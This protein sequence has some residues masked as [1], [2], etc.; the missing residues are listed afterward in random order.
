[1]LT[2]AVC[3]ARVCAQAT[4]AKAHP[5]GHEED[6]NPRSHLMANSSSVVEHLRR[7]ASHPDSAGPL[8]RTGPSGSTSCLGAQHG[9]ENERWNLTVELEHGP[10]YL[11]FLFDPP[12][13]SIRG[14]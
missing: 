7:C 13:A 14:Q 5:Q 9:P 1:M 10:R 11:Q 12:L 6:I 2:R 8:R 4:T 3:C